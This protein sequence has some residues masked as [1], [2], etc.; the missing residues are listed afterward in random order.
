MYVQN[1]KGAMP[2]HVAA[3]YA[4][5]DALDRLIHY[6]VSLNSRDSMGKTPLMLAAWRGRTHAVSVLLRNGAHVNVQD[7][8]GW[9]ALMYAAYTG[10]VAICREL[11]ESLSDRAVVESRGKCAAELAIESGFYEVADMLQNKHKVV[12]TP[13]FPGDVQMHGLHVSRTPVP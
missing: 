8:H 4:R 11:I 10:R 1:T 12:R 3:Y 5:S 7:T 6:R 9:T 2:V 13:S